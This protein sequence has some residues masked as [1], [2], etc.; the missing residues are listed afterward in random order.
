MVLCSSVDQVLEANWKAVRDAKDVCVI[1]TK[2]RFPTAVHVGCTVRLVTTARNNIYKANEI[3][4]VVRIGGKT[5]PGLEDGRHVVCAT[6]TTVLHVRLG[7]TRVVKVP[8]LTRYKT[9]TVEV[10][11]AKLA[12]RTMGRVPVGIS[13]H[14]KCDLWASN[15]DIPY[16]VFARVP[17]KQLTTSLCSAEFEEACRGPRVS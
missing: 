6:K 8:A 3:G 10:A 11:Y 7:A 2:G 14:F 16:I 5:C 4:V 12:K 13:V 15:L 1:S 17:W 9:S